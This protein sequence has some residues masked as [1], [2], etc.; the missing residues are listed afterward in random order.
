MRF[1]LQKPTKSYWYLAQVQIKT[2]LLILNNIG[3]KKKF[4]ALYA[5]VGALVAGP[6]FTSCIDDTESDSV[7]AVRT[8]KAQHLQ[9]LTKLAE[10]QTQ[11][12]ELRNEAEAAQLKADIAKYTSQLLTT[13]NDILN[14]LA[15]SYTNALSNIATAKQNILKYE[16]DLT[17]F[18]A[19]LVSI[20][21]YSKQETAKINAQIEAIE[22]AI[23]ALKSEEGVSLDA[24][25]KKKN[26]NQ[27]TL[28]ALDNKYGSLESYY[29]WYFSSTSDFENRCKQNPTNL[30]TIEAA[31]ELKKLAMHLTS[32]HSSDF[33]NGIS[34]IDEAHSADGGYLILIQE[35]VVKYQQWIKDNDKWDPDN[36]EEAK[37]LAEEYAKALGK[38]TDTETTVTEEGG[39]T[40]TMYAEL[41]VL[42]K[43]LADAQKALADAQKALA[44]N[45][46]NT[47]KAS[48]EQAVDTKEQAVEAEE[49]KVAQKIDA[50]N[51]R[52]RMIAHW[53]YIADNAIDFDA[54]IAT[55]SGKDYE[56]YKAAKDEVNAANDE[57]T[58][59]Q[60]EYDAIFSVNDLIQGDDNDVE[61]AIAR[62]E[63][64][65][66][67][68]QYQL[69]T[70]RKYFDKLPD[71]NYSGNYS[72][73][74]IE[75]GIAYS[76]AMLEYYNVKLET[77][78]IKA[79][80]AKAAWEAYIATL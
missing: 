27:E 64:N 33:N 70:I 34:F 62:L 61:A 56:A 26:A 2:L 14:N 23:T 16:N 73:V 77:E 68:K 80:Q 67:E 38:E 7:A 36:A 17:N 52:K 69:T 57:K 79:E 12:Q 39:S 21:A 4:L 5:L 29:N 65:L 51:L 54:L 66:A 42:K 24:I 19:G 20:Q 45:T 9:A 63:S 78:T 47:L 1:F 58:K 74:D 11:L 25:M 44:D 59:L 41:A 76:E 50:I 28:D 53:K 15:N 49:L 3:M 31:R 35:D 32:D 18:K 6:V 40:L 22:A 48:L 10:L 71:S 72:E 37:K 46:D 13:N 75:K 60:A 55:F 43:A 30:A 8:A